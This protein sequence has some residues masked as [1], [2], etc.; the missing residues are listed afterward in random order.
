MAQV[1]QY[2]RN[3]L[4]DYRESL[5]TLQDAVAIRVREIGGDDPNNIMARLPDMEC[6]ADDCGYKTNINTDQHMVL[7]QQMHNHILV[8]HNQQRRQPLQQQEGNG[9]QVPR[10]PKAGECPKWMETYSYEI[11]LV[12]LNQWKVNATEE[13]LNAAAQLYKLKESLKVCPRTDVKDYF[14]KTLVLDGQSTNTWD[15]L[16]NKLKEKFA[17]NTDE[18]WSFTIKK[19]REFKWND[20]KASEVMEEVERIRLEL[21]KLSTKAN[22]TEMTLKEFLDRLLAKE[23]IVEQ[24]KLEKKFDRAESM[25]L[26]KQLKDNGYEWENVKKVMKETKV[27]HDR[28]KVSDIHYGNSWD[29]RSRPRFRSNSRGNFQRNG[30]FRKDG[31]FQKERASTPSGKS[32]ASRTWSRSQSGSRKRQGNSPFQKPDHKEKDKDYVSNKELSKQIM[33]LTSTTAAIAKTVKLLLDTTPGLN[34]TIQSNSGANG[35]SADNS[36]LGANLQNPLK[37]YF[38][39]QIRDPITRICYTETEKKGGTLDCGAPQTVCGLPW[40][41]DYMAEKGLSKENM[42]PRKI[43]QH[44][45]FGSGEVYDSSEKLRIPMKVKNDR[46]E[47]YDLDLDAC[48]IDAPIPYLIGGEDMEKL[49]FNLLLGKTK[50]TIDKKPEIGSFKLVKGSGGHFLLESQPEKKPEVN[51]YLSKTLTNKPESE[52]NLYEKV[53]RLHRATKHKKE[54]QLK[55]IYK[56]ADLDSPAVTKAIEKVIQRCVT[57]QKRKK[58]RPLPTIALPKGKSPNDVVSIDLKFFNSKP[59]LWCCDEFSGFMLGS[60]LKSKEAKVVREAMETTWINVVG[61]PSTA[62]FL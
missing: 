34:D 54:E 24:G 47:I 15:Q 32:G 57:C 18:E 48:V 35:G 16:L 55:Y 28:E 11:Y 61:C 23:I 3:Q 20:K 8:Q 50:L 52:L 37:H 6:E 19:L 4:I 45:M 58:T 60:T 21:N 12:D 39:N 5:N 40:L 10:P 27:K 44:F 42:N 62:F 25:E 17:L 36:V 41:K 7:V 13:G 2:D 56:R 14:L 22:G 30:S 1:Q 59:V 53:K 46:G 43:K 29:G 51:V 33:T 26:E 49:G 38:V 9:Q 31:N